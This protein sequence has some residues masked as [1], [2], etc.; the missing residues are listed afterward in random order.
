MIASF[1]SFI[2]D[3]LPDYFMKKIEEIFDEIPGENRLER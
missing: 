1:D 3:C 2:R